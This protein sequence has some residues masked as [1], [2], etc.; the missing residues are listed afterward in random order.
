MVFSGLTICP[1]NNILRLYV[2]QILKKE[3]TPLTHRQV[4]QKNS[5]IVKSEI[6]KT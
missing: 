5:K 1:K 6:V 3:K 2:T 4:I